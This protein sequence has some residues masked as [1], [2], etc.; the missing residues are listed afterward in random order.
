MLA[1]S[2]NDVSEAQD[3]VA[4]WECKHISI[5]KDNLM[6][7]VGFMSGNLSSDNVVPGQIDVVTRS[8]MS[9]AL[10]L[11]KSDCKN[12]LKSVLKQPFKIKPIN[13][14]LR[15]LKYLWHTIF[16]HLCSQQRKCCH[17]EC[18]EL[19]STS[20]KLSGIFSLNI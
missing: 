4:K 15:V 6:L 14:L 3:G 13:K 7:T 19:R 8:T 12:V 9:N 17:E 20:E 1:S 10:T 16:Q 5:E 11:H 18:H 2:T